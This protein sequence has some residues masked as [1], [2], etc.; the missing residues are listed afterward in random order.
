MSVTF[1]A[2]AYLATLTPPSVRLG[3][4]TYTGRHL[5]AVQ[6]LRAATAVDVAR[7]KGS[8]VAWMAAAHL[9]F[10]MAFPRRPWWAIWRRSVASVLLAQPKEVWE[11]VLASFF[12]SPTTPTAVT[13]TTPAP[14]PPPSPSPPADWSATSSPPTGGDAGTPPVSGRPETA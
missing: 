6:M 14:T 1:D 8:L 5:S 4:V 2:D 9:T 11:Q 12:T 3:G 13:T 10:S 7:Q